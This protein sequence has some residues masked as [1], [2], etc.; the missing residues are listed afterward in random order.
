MATGTAI[1]FVTVDII[2][3]N[4]T[5]TDSLRGEISNGNNMVPT[6]FPS[7]NGHGASKILR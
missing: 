1:V 5:D 4:A 2:D 7:Q 6:R 3:D